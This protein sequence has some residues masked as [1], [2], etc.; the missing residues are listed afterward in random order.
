MTKYSHSLFWI[1]LNFYSLF[2]CYQSIIFVHLIRYLLFVQ[3][4]NSVIEE[5]SQEVVSNLPRVLRDIEIVKQE[6]V[7]LQD[8]MKA[9]KQDVEKVRLCIW[10][11]CCACTCIRSHSSVAMAA[12]N[13]DVFIDYLERSRSLCLPT[14]GMSLDVCYLVKTRLDIFRAVTLIAS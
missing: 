1:K 5:T 4:V 3:E 14:Q 10:Y 2:F 11:V 12:G 8:Q 9:I 7:I 6:A 13:G